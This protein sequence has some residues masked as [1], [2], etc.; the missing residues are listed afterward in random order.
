MEK[1]S[2]SVLRETIQRVVQEMQNANAADGLGVNSSA[3]SSPAPEPARLTSPPGSSQIQRNH[4][5]S[6][7]AEGCSTWF[8][9]T[10]PSTSAATI[11]AIDNN[12]G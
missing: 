1:I 5:H 3:T 4:R 11:R 6:D 9:N 12:S 8:N 7:P 10:M 2:E